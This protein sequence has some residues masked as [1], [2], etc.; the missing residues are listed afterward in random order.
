MNN[1]RYRASMLIL[2]LLMT[3][4]IMGCS[5]GFMPE[6]FIES[7]TGDNTEPPPQ[8]IT[9]GAGDEPS[10]LKPESSSTPGL[11]TIVQT[12]E[13]GVAPQ[14]PETPPEAAQP[15]A[16][17]PPPVSVPPFIP[18]ESIS[19]DITSAAIDASGELRIVHT[20][21]PADATDKTVYFETSDSS[22]ATV[23]NGG[24]VRAVG[25]GTVVIHC[26]SVSGDAR[27]SVSIT[28]VIPVTG[29]SVS[30]N[31]SVFRVGELCSFTVSVFPEDATDK[32]YTIS[33]SNSNAEDAGGNSITCISD[34]RVTITATASNGVSGSRE[35]NIVDLGQFAAEVFRLTNIERQNNGLDDFSQNS[36]LTATAAVRAAE[37][38]ELFSHTRPDGR[39]C[40]SAF[41]ENGVSFSR[42]AENIAYGQTTPAEV[43]AGWMNSP[44]HRANILNSNLGTLGTGVEMDSN[45]RLYWSQVFTD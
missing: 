11:G 38:I 28:V 22:V 4:F 31:K 17:D 20:I 9:E 42:A 14:S 33:F 3:F 29:I 40:F 36:A 24:V 41:T 16:S 21:F 44:G 18:V 8:Q 27:A 30:T 34:G 45:G 39:D 32:T 10:Q 35:I 25:A 7:F 26:V 5:G 19:L 12:P 15:S 6:A 37:S 2:A 1:K 23:T 13:A 43:V